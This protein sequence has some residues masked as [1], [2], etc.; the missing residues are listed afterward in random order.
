MTS[1]VE[2]AGYPS[3]TRLAA[4]ESWIRTT[5]SWRD[6]FQFCREGPNVRNPSPSTDDWVANPCA[7]PQ[8]EPDGPAP[9][10]QPK[11]QTSVLEIAPPT[12]SAPG[13][14]DE[15]PDPP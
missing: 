6:G 11:F 14:P 12:R 3:A 2:F 8:P 1:N 7:I 15:C 9:T 10:A 13:G 5:S 4:G